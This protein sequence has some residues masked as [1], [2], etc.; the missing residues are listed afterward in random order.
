LKL[1]KVA[2]RNPLFADPRGGVPP[3]GEPPNQTL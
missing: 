3:N 1:G 2:L